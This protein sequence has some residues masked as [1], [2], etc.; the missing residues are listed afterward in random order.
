M[1]P[2]NGEEVE[3]KKGHA[4]SL[5]GG[6]EQAVRSRQRPL[7][8]NF[9]AWAADPLRTITQNG[10]IRVASQIQLRRLQRHLLVNLDQPCEKHSR[11]LGLQ[12]KKRGSKLCACRSSLKTLLH[13]FA[14]ICCVSHCLHNCFWAGMPAQS[15]F[16][17]FLE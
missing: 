5:S 10:F 9:H 7:L 11:L 12:R 4:E 17:C 16:H 14:S 6:L 2:I 3:S 13:D 15:L 1:N 8:P